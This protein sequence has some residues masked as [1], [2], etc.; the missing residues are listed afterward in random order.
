MNIDK[1]VRRAD[2][3]KRNQRNIE[4][5][6]VQ[7]NRLRLIDM[8]YSDTLSIRTYLLKRVATDRGYCRRA[9][10]HYAQTH[11]MEPVEVMLR[12]FLSMNNNCALLQLEV[13]RYRRLLRSANAASVNPSS[14]AEKSAT[15]GS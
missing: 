3:L 13:I 6:S 2:N 7:P 14:K 8:S 4:N 9:L 10:R 15:T 12:N 1:S 11:R 5:A